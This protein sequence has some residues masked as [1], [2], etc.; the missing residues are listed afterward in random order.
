[1]KVVW[2]FAYV[3]NWVHVLLISW[4]CWV[5]HK[6]SLYVY[7]YLVITYACWGL[8]FFFLLTVSCDLVSK[9]FLSWVG[10][11]L[12]SSCLDHQLS[13]LESPPIL[14]LVSCVILSWWGVS[15]SKWQFHFEFVQ[16]FG[17]EFVWVS[18]CYGQS[19]SVGLDS[20]WQCTKSPLG[21]L[22]YSLILIIPGW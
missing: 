19:I 11:W 14:L 15:Q 8:V 5:K 10:V 1:M 6:L 7:Q 18:Q 13:C 2:W 4:S 17:T 22:S 9:V 16:Y 20:L 21:V 3:L 12:L